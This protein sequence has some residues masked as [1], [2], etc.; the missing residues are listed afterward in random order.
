MTLSE[1]RSG[2]IL[3][4]GM[5]GKIDIE[6]ANIFVAKITQILNDGERYVLL[7][8]SDVAYINSS[9]LRGLVM[10]AK[11]LQRSQGLL[12]LSGVPETV[13]RVLQMAGL[14]SFPHGAAH[15]GGVARSVPSVRRPTPAC[16]D[17]SSGSCVVCWHGQ[18]GRDRSG[19]GRP[20]HFEMTSL[21]IQS[22]HLHYDRA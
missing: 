10:A 20:R 1:E 22:E 13:S 16:P 21:P 5:K 9:G 11:Q 4:L 17:V 12:V 18:R 3:V 6:G 8:F 2:K 15:P 14:S 7:D 19:A